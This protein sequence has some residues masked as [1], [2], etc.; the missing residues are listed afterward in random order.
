[1]KLPISWVRDFIDFDASVDGIADNLTMAGLEID[2]IIDLTPIDGVVVAEVTECVKHPNADKLSVC[3]VN[4]ATEKDIPVVCG[5]PNVRAGIKVPL[6]TVGTVFDSS[7]KIKE[8]KLRGVLSK[9][10]ICSEKELG[11]SDDN[12]GIMVLPD[13]Y[14]IGNSLWDELPKQEPILDVAITPNRGDCLSIIGLAREMAVFLDKKVEVPSVSLK[15]SEVKTSDKIKVNNNDVVSCPRYTA[16]YIKNITVGDSPLWMQNRLKDAGMRPVNNIVDITNYVMLETGQPLHAFD[17]K[18]IQGQEINIRKAFDS[19]KFETLDGKERKLNSEH[20]L[21]CDKEKPI[22]LAGIMGGK[23]SEVSDTTNEIIL[24]SAHFDPVVVRVGAKKLGISTEASYRFERYVDPNIALFASDR[25]CELFEKYCGASV[26]GDVV[27]LYKKEISPLVVDLRL[28]RIKRILGIS[29]S[30]DMVI[31]LLRKID[32]EIN[33]KTDNILTVGIP[34]F[35]SDVTREIDVIEE[36]AR[37][38]GYNN[39]S[40]NPSS[41][42]YFNDSSI[43]SDDIS[44][45]IRQTMLGIG[46]LETYCN[47]LTEQ[48]KGMA[49]WS[50]KNPSVSQVTLLNP[51]SPELSALRVNLIYGLLKVASWNMNRNISDLQIFE[52]GKK[53]IPVDKKEKPVEIE[54]VAGLISGGCFPRGWYGEVKH[55]FSSAKGLLVNFLNGLF[56]KEVT[57]KRSDESI[58]DEAVS[59]LIDGKDVGF[60]GKLNGKVKQTYGLKEDVY[61][62]EL[63]VD[64]LKKQAFATKKFKALPKFPPINRDFSFVLDSSVESGSIVSHVKS[65]SP[66]IESAEWFDIYV[67][68]QV[69]KGKKSMSLSIRIRS[70]DKTLSDTE[71][72]KVSKLVINSV[73]NKFGGTLR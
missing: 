58:F 73:K 71:A 5:A 43:V 16:R 30:K 68:E 64:A 66:L 27:D 3:K 1:M 57:Y 28:D 4:T 56:V 18:K 21:I 38:Y 17:Y 7:F 13:E 48:K 11:I 32:F 34:T 54:I 6:A 19:E 45:K 20:L 37:L 49:T 40:D 42:I 53:F 8:A 29:I 65:L 44:G 22:A 55:D 15:G 69:E 62:F 25:A 36:V 2:D 24:E 70:S 63:E 23:Y 12:K 67:G 72:D 47:S 14:K 46:F 52:I 31:S 50:Y 39:I 60:I 59:V 35:R 61:V 33:E 9:G 51:H 41:V 26:A 10:M